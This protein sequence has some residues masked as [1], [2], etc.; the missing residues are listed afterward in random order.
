[1]ADLGT[2]STFKLPTGDTVSIKDAT[3]RESIDILDIDSTYTSSTKTVTLVFGPSSL[4][5][6]TEY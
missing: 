5:D 6:A 4:A 3:A 2:I 1:M